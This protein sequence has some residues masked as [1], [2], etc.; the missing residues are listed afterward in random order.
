MTERKTTEDKTGKD[1]PSRS[2]ATGG[3]TTDR[4]SSP[5]ADVESPEVQAADAADLSEGDLH[6]LRD[7]AGFNALPGHSA[8]LPAW[9]S[10]AQGKEFLKGEK[11]RTKAAEE[12][13]KAAHESLTDEGLSEAEK[14]YVETVKH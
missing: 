4:A 9:E 12:A 13:A 5:V 3:K 2:A 8:S 7:D 1:E 11:E 10:S 6:A 14:K